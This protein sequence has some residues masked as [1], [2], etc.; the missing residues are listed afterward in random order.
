MC[1]IRGW[2]DTLATIYKAIHLAKEMYQPLN[3]L[4]VIDLE[5]LLRTLSSRVCTLSGEI[6]QM[7][8]LIFLSVQIK[9]EAKYVSAEIF[10]MRGN[11]TDSIIDLCNDLDANY[12]VVGQPI[13]RRMRDIFTHQKI[14]KLN[15]RLEEDCSAQVVF[16]E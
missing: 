14:R 15:E 3:F 5:F 4:Y 12:V 9:A 16:V 6:R 8:E 10:I 13:G 2:P 1:A 11:G 7:G